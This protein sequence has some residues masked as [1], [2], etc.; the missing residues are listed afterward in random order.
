MVLST[1]AACSRPA[2]PTADAE[3]VRA[4]RAQVRGI[5]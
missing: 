2:E 1:A 4:V 3:G 5:T